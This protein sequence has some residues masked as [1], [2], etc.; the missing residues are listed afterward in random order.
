MAD[1]TPIQHKL[2]SEDCLTACNLTDYGLLNLY[3]PLMRSLPSN[4]DLKS[5][6]ISLQLTNKYLVK[7]VIQYS[8]DPDSTTTTNLCDIAK[9]FVWYRNEV[10]VRQRQRSG[11]VGS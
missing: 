7:R 9:P 3:K 8:D 2:S 10:L 1:I 5:L 11:R 6:L 4:D